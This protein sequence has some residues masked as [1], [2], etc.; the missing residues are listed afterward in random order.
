Q[1][2]KEVKEG[3]RIVGSDDWDNN[4]QQEWENRL[5]LLRLKAN[6]VVPKI[7]DTLRSI[8]IEN[9]YPRYELTFLLGEIGSDQALPVLKEVIQEKVPEELMQY[10]QS[11]GTPG[12]SYLIVK[13]QAV[14]AI[15]MIGLQSDKKEEIKG[16]LVEGISSEYRPVRRAS[17]MAMKQLFPDDPALKEKVIAMLPEKDKFFYDIKIQHEAIPITLPK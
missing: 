16:T 5:A 13:T 15:M 6:E 7:A 3:L 4:K 2:P 14:D 9:H 10:P 8:P 1:L 11:E 17:V 12:G